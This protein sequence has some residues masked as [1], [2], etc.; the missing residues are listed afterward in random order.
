M[1]GDESGS[2]LE[3]CFHR[4]DTAREQRS[5]LIHLHLTLYH[6]PGLSVDTYRSNIPDMSQILTFDAGQRL[7]TQTKRLTEEQRQPDGC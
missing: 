6:Q 5:G 1:A 3:I 4:S 2:H 7:T